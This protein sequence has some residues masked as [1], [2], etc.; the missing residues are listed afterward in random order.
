MLPVLVTRQL[1]STH[2]LAKIRAVV[3]LV[4]NNKTQLQVIQSCVATLEVDIVRNTVL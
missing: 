4:H 2:S 1:L 3:S